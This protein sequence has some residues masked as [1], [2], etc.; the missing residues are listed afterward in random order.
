LTVMK[1]Y[2]SVINTQG[3]STKIVSKSSSDIFKGNHPVSRNP[4]HFSLSPHHPLRMRQL[5]SML[6][7]DPN[8]ASYLQRL[9]WGYQPLLTL[10]A[11]RTRHSASKSSPVLAYTRL[12]SP[13]LACTR[14]YSPVLACTRLY[15]P[16]L[17]CTRLYSPVLASVTAI[18]GVCL[19]GIDYCN[20]GVCL[21]EAKS[22]RRT[23]YFTP[24]SSSTGSTG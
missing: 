1:I 3:R 15:S 13:V 21:A 16:V 8:R 5:A 6:W 10:L 2:L 24:G 23:G 17:A 22:W 9:F 19:K 20:G 18:R 14:L 4:Q 7:T 12:Y 11:S